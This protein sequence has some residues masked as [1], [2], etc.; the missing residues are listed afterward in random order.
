MIPRTISASSL[1]VAE[2]C[3]VRWNAE[4]MHRAGR[5]GG[6]AADTG[7]AVHG[8]LENFVEAVYIKREHDGLDKVKRKELLITFYQMSYMQTFGTADFDTPHFTDGRDLAMKW[9]ARTD[10]S[11]RTVLSVEQKET[12]QVPFNHPDSNHSCEHCTDLPAGQC[13]VPFNYIMDRLD[14]TGEDEYE[15]VDYKTIRVPLQ[16]DDLEAKIQARAYALAVQIKFPNAKKIK[17]TFD[18]L[19]HEQISFWFTRDDN[20]RFWRFLVAELQRI[21]DTPE[22]DLKPSMNSECAWCTVKFT[23]PLMKSNVA[24]GG[25]HALSTDE[26]AALLDLIKN[27]IKANNI[28]KDELE[29]ELMKHAA[30]TEQLR[31]ETDD[32]A[33]EVEIGTSRR[34]NFPADQ[35]AKIMGPEL[36]A[37]M[38]SMTIGN[39]ENI[40]KDESLD[41]NM[42]NNLA[43][44]LT[45]TNGNLNVKVKPKKKVF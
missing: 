12:I 31:W 35:A 16:P 27:Q 40:I 10:L 26:K 36:F 6:V 28:I 32:G 15:V 39:L 29:E 19:R 37:Q 2:L 22:A 34:R 20:I 23:C 44:L 4:Y 7:T 17:V 43:A 41:A 3:M 38:G 8:A 11:D 30:K 13:N 18:L 9:F 33:F 1:Q 42:R 24:Q 25:I 14:Q 45:W 5:A 21:V